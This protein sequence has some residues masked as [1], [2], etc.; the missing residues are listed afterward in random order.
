MGK[1]LFIIAVSLLLLAAPSFVM[2]NVKQ[3]TLVLEWQGMSGKADRKVFGTVDISQTVGRGFYIAFQKEKEQNFPVAVLGGKIV[4]AKVPVEQMKSLTLVVTLD[5]YEKPLTKRAVLFDQIRSY[6][7]KKATT[8]N[9]Y[10]LL[11]L[12]N[13]V[14]A[15]DLPASLK[16]ESAW[17]RHWQDLFWRIHR[18]AL[19]YAAQ[20]DAKTKEFEKAFQVQARYELPR[21]IF[22][23]EE[24]LDLAQEVQIKQKK[25]EAGGLFGGKL[26]EIGDEI[27]DEKKTTTKKVPIYSI[28]ILLDDIAAEGKYPVAFQSARAVRN[29]ILEGEVIYQAT[30]GSRRVVTAA[31]VFSQMQKNNATKKPA[32]NILTVDAQNI[33]T[34]DNCE[35]LW[36]AAKKE[37]TDFLK[38]NPTWKVIIPRNPVIFYRGEQ[39]VYAM[40]AWYQV[41][42]ESG[43]MKGILPNG[44]RGAFSDELAQLEKTLIEK[45]KE[46]VGEAAA[47]QPVKVFFSQVAGMYVSAAGV[48][49]AVNL[50]LCNPALAG[51]NDEQWRKFVSFHALDFCQKFLEENADLYDSYAA[52]IG[53]WQG[54]MVITSELG[55]AEAAHQCARKA[56]D[57]ATN[58]AISDAKAAV[59]DKLKKLEKEAKKEGR[60]VYDEVMKGYAP[61]LKKAIEDI[62]KVKEYVDQGK[63][64]VDKGK[65]ALDRYN[66]AVA[67]LEKE[68]KQ[69]GLL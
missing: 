61:R 49:D 20:S 60:K 53:F 42:P 59:Q 45:T 48:L 35:K 28:D 24:W 63:G 30:G 43:R 6:G 56:L 22:A 68:L 29:D 62:E 67:D 26:E 10:H 69:K 11:V 66:K 50:T 52:Q 44:T 55:G 38:E 25:K 40:Y 54:A 39:P 7:S 1:R 9:V 34:L 41:H 17:Q 2:A 3:I 32:N 58:K 31:A 15:K 65:E 4:L 64:F 8:D 12:D 19:N 51:L 23:V 57:S 33:S 47:G 5:G 21:L 18:L 27:A 13:F 37:I 14:A 16:A 46:K 36:P